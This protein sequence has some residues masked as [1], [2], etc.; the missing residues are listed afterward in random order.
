MLIEP[1]YV[2]F[3]Q[4]T[5]QAVHV[6]VEYVSTNPGAQIMHVVV[7]AVADHVVSKTS[8]IQQFVSVVATATQVAVVIAVLELETKPVAQAP[9]AVTHPVAAF[10]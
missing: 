3:V 7:D 1:S 10:A 9:A 8:A 5:G 4:F 6:F 2:A